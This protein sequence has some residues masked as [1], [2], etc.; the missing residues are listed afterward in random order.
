MKVQLK[1][2][3]KS[4]EQN[5]NEIKILKNVNLEIEDGEIVSLL[6]RSGSG[7]STLLALLAGLDKPNH[8]EVVIGDKKIHQLSEAELTKWRAENIGI[9]FQQFHLVSHLTALENVLLSLEIKNATQDKKVQL[10]LAKSWLRKVGLEERENNY[11]SMLSGGEQQ[12]V[13]I[14]RAMVAGPKLLLADEPSGNLDVETGKKVMDMLFDIIHNNKI[15]MI[16]VT[17]DE[18]L[19]KKTNRTLRLVSGECV[20]A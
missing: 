18:D 13:A 15:T 8:G 14:A 7:K 2:I 19:A 4:F 10:E 20:N 3:S 11:P 12:R 1:N 5:K 16:L 6:G 9:V 17:H